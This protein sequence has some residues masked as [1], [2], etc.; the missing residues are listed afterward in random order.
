MMFIHSPDM[1]L[2]LDPFPFLAILVSRRKQKPWDNHPKVRNSVLKLL[3]TTPSTNSDAVLLLHPWIG[4][5][6][7]QVKENLI[8][9]TMPA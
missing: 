1:S 9:S 3:T 7:E 4:M 6:S 8:E 5:Q 2:G